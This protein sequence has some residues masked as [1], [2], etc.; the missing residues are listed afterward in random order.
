MSNLIAVGYDD[1]ETAERV[2]ERL[3]ELQTR[4]VITLEDAVV[5]ERTLDGKIKLHQARS[6]VGA[7]AVG[8][9]L[10]GGLIG[11]LFFMPFLGAA[12][13][14]A[15]GAAGGSMIDAGVDD[16]F[17][18]EVG[19]Q[20]SPGR[21]ALF[22]LVVSS[23]PDKVLPEVAPYGGHILTTSLSPDAEAHL[24]ETA[25]AAQVA[26]GGPRGPVPEEVRGSA[27]YSG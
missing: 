16:N 20:L 13:G 11:L 17:M 23:T 1:V 3:R 15:A 25:R 14:A 27:Y 12:V 6:T 26:H 21:A 22:V 9:A 2:R 7:G 24:R 18:R 10:W 19:E 8:G 4:R 5:V